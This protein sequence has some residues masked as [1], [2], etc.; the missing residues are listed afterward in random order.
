MPVYE[1]GAHPQ[2]ARGPEVARRVIDQ[3]RPTRIDSFALRRVPNHRFR[4]LGPI[5]TM[6]AHPL[7]R[8]MRSEMGV[9]PKPSYHYAGV[10]SRRVGQKQFAAGKPCKK[11]REAS[12]RTHQRADVEVMRCTQEMVRI[13]AVMTHQAE[14][15]G[16]I[17]LPIGVTQTV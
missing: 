1:Y 3:N 17:P 15:R 2:R 14:Q 5:A 16:A 10:M 11:L 8:V 4:R 6:D 12:F 7:D 13:D 9:Q